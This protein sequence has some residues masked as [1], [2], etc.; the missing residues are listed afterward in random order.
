MRYV[1][2]RTLL[3]ERLLKN[4][5]CQWRGIAKTRQGV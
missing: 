3:D 4:Q 1:F 5:R 2:F